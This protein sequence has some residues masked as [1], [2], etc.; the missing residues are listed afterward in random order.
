MLNFVLNL[1]WITNSL[2]FLLL[3]VDA[4]SRPA[5]VDRLGAILK[6]PICSYLHCLIGKAGRY[7]IEYHNTPHIFLSPNSLFV[8]APR[9]DIRCISTPPSAWSWSSFL[10]QQPSQIQLPP[11]ECDVRLDSFPVEI[12]AASDV[13]V[14]SPRQLQIKRGLL[15]R[16]AWVKGLPSRCPLADG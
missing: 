2:Q 5:D 8:T 6:N 11:L 9:L 12:T 3:V 7:P 13:E 15:W 14:V 16:M 1:C 4:L 10:V